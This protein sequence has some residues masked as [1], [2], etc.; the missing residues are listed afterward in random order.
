MVGA[1]ELMRIYHVNIIA[2]HLLCAWFL[3]HTSDRHTPK[4]IIN[5]SS[6]AARYPVTHWSAYCATKAALDML[7]ECLAVEYPDCS[8]YSLAPGMIDTPMQSFIRS[9]SKQEFPDVERFATAYENNVLNDPYFVSKRII[10]LIQ[11]SKSNRAV[12]ISIKDI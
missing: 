5:I 3:R 7:S 8:V 1:E 12:K 9:R 10:H 11:N 2:A 6:G 4:T